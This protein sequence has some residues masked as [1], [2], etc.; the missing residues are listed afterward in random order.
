MA[1]LYDIDKRLEG[2]FHMEDGTGVDTETGE[3]FDAEAL[4]ALEMERSEK[5]DNIMCYIK[6]LRSDAAGYKAE[7]DKL[8]KR[9]ERDT[10]KADYLIEYLSQHMEPGKKFS[11]AH[12]EI[13][14]RK[15]ERVEVGDVMKLPEGYRNAEW[16]A[17]KTALKKAIKSGEEIS[18][19]E[20]VVTNN[21]QVR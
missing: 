11:N 9:Y 10:R 5:I 1:T 2:I 12:G 20:L 7:M 16:K 13:S 4:E 21:L 8:K 15:S 17:D 6:N 14:W 19:A 3:I 18:G